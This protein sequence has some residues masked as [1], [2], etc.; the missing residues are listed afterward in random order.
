MMVR[1]L[2]K[3]KP[4][5]KKEIFSAANSF[6]KSNTLWKKE[7]LL[8]RIWEHLSI[9]KELSSLEKEKVASKEKKSNIT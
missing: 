5:R 9:K 4:D 2:E 8:Q 6:I 7:I 3:M 1:I